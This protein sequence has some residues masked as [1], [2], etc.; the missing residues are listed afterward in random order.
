MLCAEVQGASVDEQEPVGDQD[1]HN[2]PIDAFDLV[3]D[4]L[5]GCV[6]VDDDLVLDDRRARPRGLPHRGGV[7]LRR[8]GIL[9]WV[10]RIVARLRDVGWRRRRRVSGTPARHGCCRREARWGTMEQATRVALSSRKAIARFINQ[11]N[12]RAGNTASVHVHKNSRQRLRIHDGAAL[13]RVRSRRAT[14]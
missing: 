1:N 10:H 11:Q 9:R 5:G 2:Q 4:V 12:C 8:G 14:R 13:L 7:L 6:G 3:C